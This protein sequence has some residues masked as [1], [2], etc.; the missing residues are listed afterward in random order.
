MALGQCSLVLLEELWAMPSHVMGL[1]KRS[2]SLVST[3]EVI[4]D[5]GLKEY[6][7][8]K[9]KT[10]HHLLLLFKTPMAD[11]FFYEMH[12]EMFTTILTKINIG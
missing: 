12:K 4:Y 2:P 6:F 3:W 9:R 11:F 7:I 8:Q 1:R 10:C 5:E